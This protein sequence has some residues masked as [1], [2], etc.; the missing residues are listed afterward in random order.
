MGQWD[1]QHCDRMCVTMSM[2]ALCVLQVI[3]DDT[4]RGI[5]CTNFSSH[6]ADY[7]CWGLSDAHFLLAWQKN[8]ESLFIKGFFYV[9]LSLLV[10]ESDICGCD[11]DV[12]VLCFCFFLLLLLRLATLG[13]LDFGG[14]GRIACG[15]PDFIKNLVHLKGLRDE[16]S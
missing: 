15:C 14:R 8:P 6:R 11:G 3:S 9:F 16:S 13:F 5:V 4:M 10:K 7:F 2:N 12:K 1:V